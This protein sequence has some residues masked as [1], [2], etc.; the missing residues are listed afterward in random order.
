M[1]KC[2]RPLTIIL[3]SCLAA[4]LVLPANACGPGTNNGSTGVSE[5]YNSPVNS[6]EHWH[7]HLK[8]HGTEQQREVFLEENGAR[9]R[10]I[11]QKIDVLL[12]REA[13]LKEAQIEYIE[14][15]VSPLRMQQLQHRAEKDRVEIQALA[16]E[17]QKRIAIQKSVEHG[18]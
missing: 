2:I 6:P 17:A 12:N 4:F 7:H 1:K 9:I 3:S 8:H 13:M 18:R 10:F 15:G 5:P 14:K 11:E 16:R